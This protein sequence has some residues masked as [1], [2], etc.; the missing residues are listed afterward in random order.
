MDER[1]I[2]QAILI[3]SLKPSIRINPSTA[4]SQEFE[5]LNQ[6]VF[7]LDTILETVFRTI[8]NALGA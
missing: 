3:R 1:E 6:N 7:R 5:T 2:L 4:W 8:D